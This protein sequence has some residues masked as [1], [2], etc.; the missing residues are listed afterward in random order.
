[1]DLT[2]LVGTVT[3]PLHALRLLWHFDRTG[4]PFKIILADGGA[5]NTLSNIVDC[6]HFPNLDCRY[7]R[8]RD[9]SVRAY[10]R[11]MQSAVIASDTR[12]VMICDDDDFV[13]PSAVTQSIE[14]LENSPDYVGA[15]GRIAGFQLDPTSFPFTER[16]VQGIPAAW[17]QN[18]GILSL[19]EDTP[20]DRVQKHINNYFPIYYAVYR[21]DA[22][23]TA[24]NFIC[25]CGLNDLPLHE[26]FLSLRTLAD[27]KVATFTDQVFYLRQLNT[28]ATNL[29]I[30]PWQRRMMTD[31]WQHSVHAGIGGIAPLLVEPN[32]DVEECV[33]ALK[34]SIGHFVKRACRGDAYFNSGLQTFSEFVDFLHADGMPDDRCAQFDNDVAQ[35]TESL[36]SAEFAAFVTRA[37]PSLTGKR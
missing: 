20:F 15:G 14:F 19:T 27:G 1:M 32:M 17:R 23:I 16:L 13:L 4:V 3:R 35:V 9:H 30:K 12:Y 18:Y 25:D 8:Q 31:S 5:D 37:A 26:I 6:G 22:L 21:R 28:L 36:Q 34:H 24:F 10:F 11:K 7:F 29:G 33:T 2:L